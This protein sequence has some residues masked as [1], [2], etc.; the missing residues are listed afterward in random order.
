MPVGS[1]VKEILFQGKPLNGRSLSLCMSDYRASGTGGYE[2]YKKCPVLK[3]I[4]SEVPELALDY[5]RE[6]PMVD[7]KKN[8]SIIIRR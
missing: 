3:R 7:I 1:R 6:Y 8:G 4:G 5:L 2:G